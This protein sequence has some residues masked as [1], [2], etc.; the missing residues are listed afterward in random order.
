MSYQLQVLADAPFSFWKLDGS[1]PTYADSAGSFRQADL[2]G[3][4]V[5]HPALVTG[6]GNALVMS[7]INR[8]EMDDPVFNKGYELRQFSL[9]AWVK[10]LNVTGTVSIMSHNNTYDGLTITPTTIIFKTKYLTAGECTVTYKYRAGKS[11]HVV[12]VHTNGKNSLYVDGQLV[13]ETDM[14]DEQEIDSY[15]FVTS[16]LIAGQTTTGDEIAVDAPAIYTIPLGASVISNHYS[17]G[18]S[19]DASEALA[20]FNH[21]TFWNFSDE[22]RTIAVKQQWQLAD[23]WKSGVSVDTVVID[24]TIAPNYTQTEEDSVVDGLIVPVYTNT[25]V[26]GTWQASLELVTVPE[27]TLADARIHWTGEGDFTVE[28]SL[29]NGATWLSP[30]DAGAAVLTNEDSIDIR[31][32]FDGG[33]Q[34]DPSYVDF[35]EVVVYTNKN[36]R[37]SRENRFA[38]LNGTGTAS[39]AYY[40]PIEYADVNGM[41]IISGAID[42]TIDSSFN[43]EEESLDELYINGVDMWIKPT[44]GNIITA[45]G[46]SIA[47][48]GDNITFAGFSSVVVN[49]IPVTSGSTVFGSDS[50]YHIGAMLTTP[51]NPILH[52]GSSGDIISQASAIYG[53]ISEAGLIQIYNAYLGIPGLT[54]NDSSTVNIVQPANP[55]NIYAHVWGITPA[56]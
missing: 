35:I 45:G 24:D 41:R 47:R 7:N 31:V 3:S 23:D 29:D 54:V 34:D 17:S 30:T 22:S 40:E 51:A 48:S 2:V 21:A 27:A 11:F 4:A 56:G 50:W 39:P 12:G 18:T 8:V 28:Y 42:V 1:G 33:I 44:S 6:S 13:G 52:I 37:G 43:G 15:A 20:G 9:E 49:G 32:T 14:T 16:D 19:V 26:T 53:D 38:S 36:F 25:S 10:P 5:L 46:A 55:T